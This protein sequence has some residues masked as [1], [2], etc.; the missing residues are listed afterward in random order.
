MRMRDMPVPE[1]TLA[2]IAQATAGAFAALWWRWVG[3]VSVL[4]L[5]IVFFGL[6]QMREPPAAVFLPLCTLAATGPAD[7][8]PFLTAN[9]AAM[10]QMMTD[11]TIRPTGDVDH[12]FV[13][14]MVPH[15]QGAIEMAQ[16]LLGYGH[17]EALRRLA[18]EIIVTQ[19]QETAA[20]RLALGEKLPPSVAAPDQSSDFS[21]A[22]QAKR[23]E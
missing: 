18:Q 11:M 10:R 1:K 22:P 6:A 4:L 3:P 23:S 17:N 12:D 20:M 21:P 5:C 7:E 8:A 16:A 19:Q 13:E 2:P 9:D 14:M 15:H